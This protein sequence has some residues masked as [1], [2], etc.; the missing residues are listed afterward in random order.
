MRV[1][2]AGPWENG[3]RVSSLPKTHLESVTG[4]GDR[5]KNMVVV[6]SGDRILGAGHGSAGEGALQTQTM[7]ESGKIVVG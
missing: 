7:I 2:L 3:R 4:K 1:I 6:F 5:S